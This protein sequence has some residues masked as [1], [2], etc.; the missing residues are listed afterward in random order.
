M[1]RKIERIDIYNDEERS[2]FTT[3]TPEDPKK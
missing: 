3:S 1:R 2:F